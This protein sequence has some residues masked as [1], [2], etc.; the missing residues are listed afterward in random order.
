MKEE[1]LVK[2]AEDAIRE[3]RGEGWKRENIKD[4]VND[5]CNEMPLKRE[6]K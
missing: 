4:I 1:V 6:E 2:V 5:I 3:L